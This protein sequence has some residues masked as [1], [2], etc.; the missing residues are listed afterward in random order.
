[1]VKL[2]TNLNLNCAMTFFDDSCIMQDRTSTAP[3]GAGKQRDY[4]SRAPK[5]K[6]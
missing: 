3:I 6:I 2:C 1:M 4:Y 5:E